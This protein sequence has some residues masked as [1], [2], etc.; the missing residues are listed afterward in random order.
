MELEMAVNGKVVLLQS[1]AKLSQQFF[2]FF[3]HMP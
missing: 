1:Y 3:L 2:A